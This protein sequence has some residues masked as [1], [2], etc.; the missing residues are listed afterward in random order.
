MDSLPGLGPVE[1]ELL[2]AVV[3]EEEVLDGSELLLQVVE[4]VVSGELV[5]DDLLH[6]LLGLHVLNVLECD[7]L[8]H[9]DSVVLLCAASLDQQGQV[10]EEDVVGVLELALVPLVALLEQDVVVDRQEVNELLQLKEEED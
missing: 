5:V 8:D 3:D 6:L 1:I 4:S 7:S 9:I 2:D 10:V